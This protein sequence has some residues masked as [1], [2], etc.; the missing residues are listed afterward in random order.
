MAEG[1][2]GDLLSMALQQTGAEQRQP[3]E[4]FPDDLGSLLTQDYFPNPGFNSQTIKQ[5]PVTPV[6]NGGPASYDPLSMA[7]ATYLPPTD[8]RPEPMAQ[9]NYSIIKQEPTDYQQAP[10][11]NA[12]KQEPMDYQPTHGPGL[13]SFNLEDINLDEFVETPEVNYGTTIKREFPQ[14]PNTV[15]SK[16]NDSSLPELQDDDLTRLLNE[17]AEF[18]D[19]Q[20]AAGNFDPQSGREYTF[21]P[22]QVNHQY[23][24]SNEM[25]VNSGLLHVG[26]RHMHTAHLMRPA[27]SVNAPFNGGPRTTLGVSK[28]P[29]MQ[30]NKFRLP[31]KSQ[32]L[33]KY[34]ICK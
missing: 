20:K 34:A 2:L 15:Y 27:G 10:V 24:M 4:S 22:R 13:D 19:Y 16:T 21:P 33:I 31:T 9:T 12:I 8:M 29:P 28:P 32:V 14:P 11:F 1:A 3:N 18:N 30:V 25:Q 23:R 7:C 26:A 17:V 5:E 6:K